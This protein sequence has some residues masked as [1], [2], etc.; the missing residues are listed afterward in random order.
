MMVLLSL[1]LWSALVAL[2]GLITG[3]PAARS[4]GVIGVVCFFGLAFLL[5]QQRAYRAR[6][7]TWATH[8]TD[9]RPVDDYEDIDWDWKGRAA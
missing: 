5:D 8:L 7:A 3:T 1:A 4:F 9:E 2:A 6:R